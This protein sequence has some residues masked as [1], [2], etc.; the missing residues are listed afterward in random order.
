MRRDAK[1]TPYFSVCEYI[2]TSSPFFTLTL[3]LLAATVVQ[4]RKW[5]TADLNA[6]GT[7]TSRVRS[8]MLLSLSMD[9]VLDSRGESY[10][11]LLGGIWGIG[12]WSIR[13]TLRSEF[14]VVS[15]A[16]S[17]TDLV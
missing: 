2:S 9:A 12:R 5:Y 8:S 15:V 13:L 10:E 17:F 11:T 16:F 3:G 1:S 4:A 6:I 7:I 14:K